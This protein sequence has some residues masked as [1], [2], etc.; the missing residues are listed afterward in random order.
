MF[1]FSLVVILFPL[2]FEFDALVCYSNYNCPV[3]VFY[4]IQFFLIAF[5]K[6]HSP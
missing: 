5:F 2:Q 6:A 3:S 4:N 1:P